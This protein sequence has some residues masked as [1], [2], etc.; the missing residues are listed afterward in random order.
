M[1]G[2]TKN[3]VDLNPIFAR[4]EGL[5]LNYFQGQEDRGVLMRKGRQMNELMKKINERMDE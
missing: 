1:V 2:N 3:I 5:W 4:Q